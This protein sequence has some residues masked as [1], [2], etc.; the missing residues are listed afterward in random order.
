[1]IGKRKEMSSFLLTITILGIALVESAVIYGFIVA[2]SILGNE[3]VTL[4]ASI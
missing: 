4:N 1:M 3:A 2:F